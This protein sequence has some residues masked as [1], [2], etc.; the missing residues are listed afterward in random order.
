MEDQIIIRRKRGRPYG[1]RLSEETKDRIRR[2]RL[3]CCHTKETKDKISRSLMAYFRK[4]DSLS[5]SLENEYSYL[6]DEAVDW[7]CEHREDIDKTE[8]VM[9]ERRLMYLRQLEICIGSDIEYLFGHNI[10]PE[11]LMILKEEIQEAGQ[12]ELELH[13]LV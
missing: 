10:T 12:N 6:S 4:R 1:H 9:T 7:V 3:G 11:F 2:K 8:H 13:S 5:L